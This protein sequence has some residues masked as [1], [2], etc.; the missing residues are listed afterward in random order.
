VTSLSISR[1]VWISPQKLYPSPENE[2]LYT[3]NDESLKEFAECVRHNGVLEPLVLTKDNF[4][5]SGHRRHAAACLAGLPKVPCRKLV[6][7][8]SEID[9]DDY[10][11]LLREFNRQ[12]A[13]TI[14]EILRESVIDANPEAAYQSLV[15]SRIARIRSGQGVFEI[16]G[17]KHRSAISRNKQPML[18][19][20]TQVIQSRRDFWPLNDRQIH[21]CLLSAPPL[22]H[23]KKPASRYTNDRASYADLCDLL[24]RARI[25]GLLPWNAITDTTRPVST[26]DTVRDVGTYVKEELSNLFTRYWRDLTQSQPDHHEIIIEKNASLAVIENV[27]MKYSL[28]VTSG[29]GQCSKERLWQIEQRFRRSRKEKL[30]LLILTDFDP[31]GDAIANA[32]ALSLRDDLGVDQDRL[33]AVR[34]ALRPDQIQQYDLPRSLEA[35]PTSRNYSKFV[36]RHGV[37]YAVEL[38]ALAPEHLQSELDQAIRSHMDVDLFNQEV[39]TEKEEATRLQSLKGNVLRLIKDKSLA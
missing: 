5:I 19:A 17:V 13:K 33:V 20:V 29:R 27:A 22:R 14:D 36:A 8:R 21:Y 31:D 23:A 35:K 6:L 12:R 39:E 32:N 25:A 30:V 15:E 7:K 18:A 2:Q 11:K 37:S 34:V 24:T 1:L 9:H 10:V 28:P 26:W 4:I 38:E 3:E 16:E